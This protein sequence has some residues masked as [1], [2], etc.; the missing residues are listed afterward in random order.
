M[1]LDVEEASRSS[2]V[3]IHF[4][5]GDCI[6]SCHFHSLSAT[7]L[8]CH[9]FTGPLSEAKEAIVVVVWGDRLCRLRYGV[10]AVR[11]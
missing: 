8:T 9:L 7:C 3:R 11:I 10:H 4:G 6:L 5:D 2:F 1:I